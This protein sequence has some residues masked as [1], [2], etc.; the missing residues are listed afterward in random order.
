MA[1]S[2]LCLKSTRIIPSVSSLLAVI[3]FTGCGVHREYV[4]RGTVLDTIAIR[5]NR[6]EKK[7]VKQ[8]EDITRVRA[9]GL[10]AIERLE[11]QISAVDAELADLAE[12]IERIGRR[13]G[14]W[15]GEMITNASTSTETTLVALDTEVAGID[16]DQL[17]NSA[18]LDFTKGEYQTAIMGFRRFIQLF[19][20]SE[21]ADNAQYWVGECFYSLNQL[22]S[23]EAEFK[24]VKNR[25]PEG[26]KV[27]AALYKLGLIYQLEG[28]SSAAQEKFKEVIENYPSSA[29]AKLAQERLK[30]R[31]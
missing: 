23:A 29:E 1:V 4:R 6:I 3:F 17:Y 30:A 24:Q 12:R 16:A 11:G 15:R 7:Q 26:N 2:R 21:M 8:E 10:N 19:P 18:Y 31:Q 20:S 5:L 13:V 27:P 22:D 9:E 14:A 28:K 25:Y